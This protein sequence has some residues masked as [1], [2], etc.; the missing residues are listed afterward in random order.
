MH[1]VVEHGNMARKAGA[2]NQWCVKVSKML[3]D[4]WKVWEVLNKI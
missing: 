3:N 2:I 4:K 1:N